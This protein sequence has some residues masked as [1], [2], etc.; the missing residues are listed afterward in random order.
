MPEIGALEGE[1]LGD[2]ELGELLGWLEIGAFEGESLGD[3]LGDLLG[4][5]EIGAFEG[6]SLGDWLGFEVVGEEDGEP[7]G[8][9]KL[10]YSS[11]ESK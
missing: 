11:H 7:G 6:E 3:W 10:Q 1:R 9:P 8:A 5:L 2:L 4:W